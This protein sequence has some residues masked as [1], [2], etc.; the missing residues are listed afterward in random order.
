[1]LGRIVAITDPRGN[2]L[3]YSYDPAGNLTSFTDRMGN[4]V[5]M[6]YHAEPAHYLD[7]VID[8]PGNIALKATYK[9]DTFDGSGAG[10]GGG[11]VAQ[12]LQVA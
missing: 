8:P 5:R 2:S 1:M 6:T 11:E 3:R 9:L 12:P 7:T 10:G 4:T